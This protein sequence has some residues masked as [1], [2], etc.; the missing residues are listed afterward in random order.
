MFV[1]LRGALQQGHRSRLLAS[2]TVRC[3]RIVAIELGICRSG[4]IGGTAGSITS[5]NGRFLE[6]GNG[7]SC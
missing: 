7:T 1:G 6:V 3:R 5:G 4:R 2:A